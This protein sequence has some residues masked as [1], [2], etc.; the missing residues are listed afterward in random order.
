MTTKDTE[1]GI[2]KHASQPEPMDMQYFAV[3]AERN[4]WRK[5]ALL[6]EEQLAHRR[7]EETEAV[8]RAN[9]REKWMFVVFTIVTIGAMVALDAG[10]FPTAALLSWLAAM[11]AIIGGLTQ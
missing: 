2:A 1:R 6:A 3:C 8:R 9:R 4:R 5:R 11:A 10:N 7:A